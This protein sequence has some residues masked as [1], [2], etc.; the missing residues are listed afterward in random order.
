VRGAPR[1]PAG[2]VETSGFIAA[3]RHRATRKIIRQIVDAP[4]GLERLDDNRFPGMFFRPGWLGLL[5][6][7][8]GCVADARGVGYRCATVDIP[9]DV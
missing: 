8:G 9:S 6:S 3:G 2:G 5:E 7:A 4:C 1:D